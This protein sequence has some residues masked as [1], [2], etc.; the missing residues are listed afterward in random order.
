MK[1]PNV[2]QQQ[3]LVDAWEYVPEGTRVVVRKDNGQEYQT[4]VTGKARLLGATQPSSG[5]MESA[6][7]I[8]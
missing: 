3:S 1:K 8:P 2:N 6:D 4:T 7:A 5:S